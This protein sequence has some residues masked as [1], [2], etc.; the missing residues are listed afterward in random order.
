MQQRNTPRPFMPEELDFIKNNIMT[1][2]I[3]EMAITLKRPYASV[4]QQASLLRSPLPK[5]HK[6]KLE[7]K[8]YNFVAEPTKPAI[9]RPPAEYSNKSYWP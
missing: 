5:I 7:K 4:Y 6:S 2:T 3:K 8:R 1:M 9:K